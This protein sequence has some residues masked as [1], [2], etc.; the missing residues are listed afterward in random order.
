MVALAL[1]FI[2]LIGLLWFLVIKLQHLFDTYNSLYEDDYATDFKNELQKQEM[3]FSSQEKNHEINTVLYKR[4]TELGWKIQ[5][6]KVQDVAP[7]K[8][9]FTFQHW[10]NSSMNLLKETEPGPKS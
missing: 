2:I 3:I 1:F 7:K 5:R 6:M 4:L 8:L 9:T 10:L